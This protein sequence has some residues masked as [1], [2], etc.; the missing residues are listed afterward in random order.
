[1]WKIS[2]ALA[3]STAILLIPANGGSSTKGAKSRQE[4][5]DIT[6]QGRPLLWREPADITTRDLIYGSGGKERMPHGPFTFVKEDMNGSNPKFDVRASDG[7]KWKVK[8]GS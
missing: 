7:V 5:A 8:M 6:E 2:K 4:V 3:I 1:M